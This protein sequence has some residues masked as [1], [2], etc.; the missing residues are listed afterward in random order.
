VM[1]TVD[2][3]GSMRGIA[4]SAIPEVKALELP[5]FEPEPED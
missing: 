1:N 3:Y 2:M 5:D 4:G